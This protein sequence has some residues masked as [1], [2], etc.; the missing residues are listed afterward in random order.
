MK[1]KLAIV[2][3]SLGLLVTQLVPINDATYATSAS[4]VSCEKE[5][6]M[7]LRAWYDGIDEVCNGEQPK[8]Q[9]ALKKII[10]KVILN[11]A[12]LLLQLSGYICVGFVIWGGY[13]YMLSRGDPNKAAGGKRTIT[14]ALIGIVICITASLI[15]G[16]I[17]DISE[18]AAV[19]N[20]ARFFQEIFNHAFIWAGIVCVIIMIMG[21]IS[22]VTSVGNPQKIEKAKN[23]IMNAAIGLIITLVAAAI[24]NLVVATV[25]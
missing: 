20:G 14:N 8:D 23:T 16:A 17:V 18:G 21:G 19:N 13:L 1:K 9:E 6:F 4:S 11:V 2:I 25:S 15:S 22:Y 12:A 10:W 5:H 24:V 7:G 3:V